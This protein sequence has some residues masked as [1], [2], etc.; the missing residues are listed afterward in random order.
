MVVA[1]LMLAL[2]R[3]CP[4]PVTVAGVP[5]CFLPMQTWHDLAEISRLDRAAAS[6]RRLEARALLRAERAAVRSSSLSLSLAALCDVHLRACRSREAA[7][8]RDAGTLRGLLNECAQRPPVW[9]C[10]VVTGAAVIA[11]AAVGRMSCGSAGP[12]VV[13]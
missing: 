8:Y 6:D 4:Q 7:C 2:A 10:G 12:I 13:R 5:G 3:P 9:L 1:L 11:G